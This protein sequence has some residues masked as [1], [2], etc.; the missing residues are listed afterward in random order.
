MT[1]TV[2][3]VKSSTKMPHITCQ[4]Q[5][6]Q[7][8]TDIDNY[9]GT[10]W[11]KNALKLTPLVFLR[12]GNLRKLEWSEV[13]KD[14]MLLK[15]KA[16]KMKTKKDFVQP[17]STHALAIIKEMRQISGT[18]RYVFPLNGKANSDKPISE[19]AIRSAL[20]RMDYGGEQTAHGFRHIA[21]TIMQEYKH[22]H[23]CDNEI[24]EAAL[25]HKV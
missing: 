8:L 17:L 10:I 6:S 3:P 21:R 12:P 1:S 5:L 14:E 7:L 2:V 11:T 15:I 20:M 9:K 18:G 25:A 23:G 4:N 16:E 24:L 19:N 22:E 13:L